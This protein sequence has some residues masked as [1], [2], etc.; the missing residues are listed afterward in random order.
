M[1]NFT[2]GILMKLVGDR[3]LDDNPNYYGSKAI[4]LKP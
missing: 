1:K 4:F 3:N 2:I